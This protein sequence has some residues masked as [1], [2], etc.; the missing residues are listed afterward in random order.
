MG[1]TFK[2]LTDYILDP[3]DIKGKIFEAFDSSSAN[4]ILACL[5]LTDDN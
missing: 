2:D 1:K 3:D 5:S 4:E